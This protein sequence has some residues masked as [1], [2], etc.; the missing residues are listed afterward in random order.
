[1]QAVDRDAMRFHAG[2]LTPGHRLWRPFLFI[3]LTSPFPSRYLT[4]ASVSPK[5]KPFL[6][7]RKLL[8]RFGRNIPGYAGC[9]LEDILGAVTQRHHHFMQ[10]GA[11]MFLQFGDSSMQVM[12]QAAVSRQH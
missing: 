12:H 3:C 6:R 7:R 10:A 8:P 9:D 1:M 5:A 4:W 2:R 11:V